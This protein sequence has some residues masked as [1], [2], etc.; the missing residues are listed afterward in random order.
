MAEQMIPNNRTQPELSA[1]S[2][3][4]IE[5]SIQYLVPGFDLRTHF[6]SL[7][8][9]QQKSVRRYFESA[10]TTAITQ[11]RDLAKLATAYD[12]TYWGEDG[13]LRDVG[14]IMLRLADEADFADRIVCMAEA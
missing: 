3:N 6:E 10:R 1:K 13:I 5:A 4:S 12:A 2:D 14:W 7:S 11:A 8:A 9:E